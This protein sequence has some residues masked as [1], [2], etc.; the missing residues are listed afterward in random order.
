M[1][2]RRIAVQGTVQGVG[3]RPFVYQLAHRLH[4]RGSVKNG[5]DGVTIDAFAETPVLDELLARLRTELPPAAHIDSLH[6]Q[7]LESE[8]PRGFSIT[9]SEGVAPGA[10]PSLPADLAMCDACRAEIHDPT[11]RRFQYPFTNCTNCGPRFSIATGVPY[12]RPLTTMAPFAMCDACRA[13]YENPLDRRFHAQ[14]IACP[15]CGPKLSW[16]ACTGDAVEVDDPL[17]HAAHL[18][19]TGSIVALRG[20]GGFHLACDATDDGVVCALRQRKHRDE[21]PFAVMVPDVETAL[22]IADLTQAELALLTSPAR[23][24]VLAR[25]RERAECDDADAPAVLRASC[26]GGAAR[27]HVRDV[28]V[29][30]MDPLLSLLT[31]ECGGVGKRHVRDLADAAPGPLPTLFAGSASVEPPRFALAPAVAP[32]FR[33]VGLFLPYT[34]MHELLMSLVRRPLVMTSGNRSNEP[35][36]TETGEAVSRLAGIADGFLVHD[37]PIATRCDDSVARVVLSAPMVLRR[38]RGF[39]PESHPSP[40]RVREPLLAVGGQLKNTFCLANG[41]RLTLGPHVGDLEDLGTYESFVSMV[42]RLERFLDVKPQVLVHDLHPDYDTTRYA[43]QRDARVRI[44][45]QHHHAHVAAV[46]AE[47]GLRGPV[48]GVAFDGAGYGQDGASWGGEV[49][50]ADYASYGRV[51]TLRPLRLV[52]GERAIHEPWR[53]AL[54][55]LDDAFDGKAPLEALELFQRVSESDLTN[56]KL[57]LETGFQVMRAHGTGRVFDAVAALTFV[58]PVAAYEAQLAMMLEQAA[59]GEGE[60]WPYHLDRTRVP[61]EIDL[62]PM[63]H[64]LVADLLAG[65]PPST[66]SARLHATLAAAT[67]E[68]VRAIAHFKGVHPVVLSGGCFANARLSAELVRRLEGLEVKLPRRVPPGDGGLALGQAAVAAA[69]LEGE[70]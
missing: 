26:C 21:K 35:M 49:L 32:G 40:R 62:R 6:W 14:P 53:I 11:A 7:P 56:V 64:T 37:R 58:K 15:V 54:A 17:A 50:L 57:L 60:P 9:P 25:L 19:L 23:P 46:M 69:R 36:C 5:P 70:P 3:F 16:L 29:A 18:L 20:L 8:E 4:L 33:Q 10:R 45:V 13:E 1:T 67:A 68:T 41:S 24:I 30:G 48:I 39:V 47:Y 12:D 65:S 38:A 2:G 59:E 31:C 51:A 44:G 43:L 55:A 52:G 22:A 63:W 27:L 28:A 42:E 61:W 66:I 34:P